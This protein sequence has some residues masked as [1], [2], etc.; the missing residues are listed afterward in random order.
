MRARDELRQPHSILEREFNILER[1]LPLGHACREALLAQ[2]KR[3]TVSWLDSLGQ[4]AILFD[5][6]ND[7]EAAPCSGV[8][9]EAVAVDRDRGVI[10]LLLHAKEGRL[11]EVELFREDGRAVVDF[12][13]IAKLQLE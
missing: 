4:P 10:H 3:A 1:M 7:V 6:P 13:D 11:A 8:V 2:A 5:V 9:A 12:P